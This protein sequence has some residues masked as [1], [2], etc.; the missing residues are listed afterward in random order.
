MFSGIESGFFDYSALTGGAADYVYQGMLNEVNNA[1]SSFLIA[2]AD[3]Y[4]GYA[5]ARSY[6]DTA[7]AE[8]NTFRDNLSQG[9]SIVQAA[10]EQA[11]RIDEKL[12]R[13]EQLAEMAA[14]GTY[15][16]QEVAAFQD[17]FDSILGDIDEIAIK[18][19]TAGQ[20]VFIGTGNID[21]SVG[22]G[23][24]IS[25]TKKDLTASALG[26][27]EDMDLAN[28]PSAAL[29]AVQNARG[30]MDTYMTGLDQNQAD[31]ESADEIL[32]AN[33]SD[34]LA[35]KNTITSTDAAWQM[36][37]AVMGQM[38]STPAVTLAAQAN[39]QAQT[40]MILLLD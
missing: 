28:D 6:V 19:S 37:N 35:I 13:L 34:L 40:A 3:R 30:E 2:G 15:S 29:A 16:S 24:D 1:S 18:T 21:V 7:L 14:S 26:L 33:K 22:D 4:T 25:I 5:D 38:G 17:E 31:L 11:G 9:T 23:L 12:D 32:A 39:E 10:S 20:N 36:V 8:L 27:V